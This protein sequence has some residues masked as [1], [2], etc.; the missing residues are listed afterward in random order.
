MAPKE[1]IAQFITKP[2]QDEW[3]CIHTFRLRAT[4]LSENSLIR[5]GYDLSASFSWEAD[6]NP[7][8]T[9]MSALPEEPFRS[10]LLTFRH[11]WAQEEP[12]NFLRVLKIAKRHAPD[13]REFADALKTQWN[14][15]LFGG[16]MDMSF[17][18][19]PLTAD[20]IF[21]LWFNAHHFHNDQSK[22]RELEQLSRMLPPDWVK[23]LLASATTQ[24]CK[25]IF[26]LNHTLRKLNNPNN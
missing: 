18:D 12:P 24:C 9:V 16:L 7:S 19:S 3:R 11:F 2:S 17:N 14:S 25:L 8:F 5:S 26:T 6:K 20:R 23:F 22:Q 21:D 13:A 1:I 10:L 15:A 4:E